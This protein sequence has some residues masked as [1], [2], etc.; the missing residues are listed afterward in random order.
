MAFFVTATVFTTPVLAAN[1]VRNQTGVTYDGKTFTPATSDQLPK[2]LPAGTEGYIYT[3]DG[4]AYFL[5]TSGDK[6]KAT[7][8]QYVIYDSTPSGN[9]SNPSP[10]VAVTIVSAPTSVED[11]RGS[12][13]CDTKLFE[14]VGWII[15]PT[16]NFLASMMDH[17]YDALA[18]FLVVQP[19]QTDTNNSLF[20]MWAIVRDIANI[21]FVIAFMI[22]V[23][24]QITSIGINN[25]GIKRMLPRLILAAIF[26]NISYW[27]SALAVDISNLLGYSIHDMFM[28]LLKELNSGEQYRDITWTA[29]STAILSGATVVGGLG[30][31]GT[32]AM[33]AAGGLKASIILLAPILVGVLLAVLIALLI[34]AARQALIT[35]LII[36]S[37]LAF[38]AYVLPNTEKYFERWRTSFLTM[39]M[40]FPIFSFIFGGAQLAGLAIIQNAPR[41][42]SWI[43]IVILGLAVQVAPVVITPL[44]I[45]FSGSLLGKIAGFVNNPKAG[46]LDKTR[47]WSRD[48]AELEKARVLAGRAPNHLLNRGVRKVDY[49]RRKRERLK[50]DYGTMADNKFDEIWSKQT[51]SDPRHIDHEV[52]MRLSVDKV[53]LEKAK[54][55]NVYE[56]LKANKDGTGINAALRHDTIKTAENISLE[57]MRKRQAESVYHENL[58]SALL[59]NQSDFS[60]AAILDRA[61]GVGSRDDVLA[62]V[63]AKE[64]KEFGEHANAQLELMRHFKVTSADTKALALGETK[65]EVKDSHGNVHV[66]DSDDGPDGKNLSAKYVRDAAAEQIFTVGAHNDKVDVIL[67]TWGKTDADGIVLKDASGKD[68][69]GKTYDYRA[70]I[71]QALIKSGFGGQSPAFN[72][73]SL[74]AILK[75]DFQ[76]EESLIYHSMREILEG[77]IKGDTI[78]RA[79]DT[80]LRYLFNSAESTDPKF[81]AI[82]NRLSDSDKAK[83]QANIDE[84]RKTT[85]TVLN[86]PTILREASQESI[87]VMKAFRDGDLAGN[88]TFKADTFDPNNDRN[89]PKP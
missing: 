2:N 76:G 52:S 47:N 24:S 11:S 79:N 43:N 45:K 63:I 69:K 42:G 3:A 82:R 67:E 62:D 33:L 22:I 30:A 64:R 87:N 26:V 85:D 68:I 44:L 35:I 14:G 74:D 53:S 51:R 10:P 75:G 50:K 9:Y 29:V 25:Y 66:F 21:C 54:L 6:T 61:A 20:R 18:S 37:P 73:K 36:I 41:D 80:A 19:V 71:Q 27:I 39:L 1:A 81:E 60:G 89:K 48:R 83:L 56:E 55:D 31:Y 57:G 5:L 86:T 46:V 58:N 12:T 17:L 7:S 77:R 15:C 34:M 78:A 28:T 4:K 16:V 49:N 8:A 88:P 23:Y 13:S 38:V 70:T 59:R 65:V 40:L 32:Y 72:D 84:L